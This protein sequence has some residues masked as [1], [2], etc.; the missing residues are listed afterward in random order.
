VD[1]YEIKPADN[2]QPL[3]KQMIWERKLLDF[4][5]RNNLINIR[6]G[7]RVLQLNIK[8]SELEDRIY[9]GETLQLDCENTACDT[10]AELQTALKFIYR[11]SR[12]AMEENGANSLFLALGTLQWYETPKN[13]KARLAPILLLPVEIIRKGGNIGYVIRGRD[14]DIILNITLV[15][16]L[17]QQF[18]ID[19][20]NMNPLP[21]DEKGVDV[22]AVFETLRQH[23]ASQQGWEVQENSMLGIFSFNKFVMWNDIHTNADKLKENVILASLMENRITWEDQT[24]DADARQADKTWEPAQ[25]SIPLDVDS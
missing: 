7:K 13:E 22:H 17:K 1:N 8:P 12:T 14:E 10:E 6:F 19:I 4:S 2:G 23:I 16:F 15:E 9:D 24:P 18:K 3:T 11:T 5:L 25:F 21:K 20:S